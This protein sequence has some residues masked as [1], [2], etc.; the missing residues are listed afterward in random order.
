[1][2][3]QVSPTWLQSLVS[4]HWL[5][6]KHLCCNALLGS[7]RKAARQPR[8]SALLGDVAGDVNDSPGE[9]TWMRPQCPAPLRSGSHADPLLQCID[10]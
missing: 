5:S 4:H 9:P 8:C 7:G 2:T 6:C 3:V 1:M 10:W